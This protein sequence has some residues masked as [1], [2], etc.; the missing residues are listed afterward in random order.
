M[1][2]TYSQKEKGKKLCWFYENNTLELQN[3]SQYIL[4]F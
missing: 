4:V 1:D 2:K 3:W